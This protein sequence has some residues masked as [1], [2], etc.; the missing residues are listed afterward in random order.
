MVL[1]VQ[2]MHTSSI[3]HRDLKS[4]NM[5]LIGNDRLVLGDLGIS[6][7]SIVIPLFVL[8]RNS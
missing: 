7:V 5:F 4:Q 3:I 6:K 2:Y 8:K 1:G